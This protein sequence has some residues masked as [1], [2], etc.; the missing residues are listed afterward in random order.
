MTIEEI[1]L[2]DPHI[3]RIEPGETWDFPEID[4]SYFT[5]QDK[6]Y[7]NDCI[8][9]LKDLLPNAYIVDNC[10]NH[11]ERR[12]W[13]WEISK[14][15]EYNDTISEMFRRDSLRINNIRGITSSVMLLTSCY[16]GPNKEKLELLEDEINNG[17]K[18]YDTNTA[19]QKVMLVK[20]LKQKTYAVLQ[21]LAV[22]KAV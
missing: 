2:Q 10:L 5:H 21:F 17:W 4:Y 20:S 19:E 12:D 6:E 7:V 22:K 8:T 15:E 13:K 18:T 11:R 3:V 16:I 1:L 14:K 9:T